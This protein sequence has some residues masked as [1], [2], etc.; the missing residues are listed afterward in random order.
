M[1][2][3]CSACLWLERNEQA[4]SVKYLF[5]K[6]KSRRKLVLSHEELFISHGSLDKKSSASGKV[7][8]S[9]TLKMQGHAKCDAVYPTSESLTQH[10]LDRRRCQVTIASG[11][12]RPLANS[13]NGE[14]LK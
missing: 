3:N 4:V 13:A 14:L 6:E 2:R 11:R 1:P 9:R 12:R 8:E 5:W 7:G 10:W